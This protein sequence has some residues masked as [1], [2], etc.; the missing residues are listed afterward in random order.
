MSSDVVEACSTAVDG[1]TCKT[2]TYSNT[3]VSIFVCVCVCVTQWCHAYIDEFVV[4]VSVKTV[5]GCERRIES[6][7]RPGL[8]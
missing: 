2:D 7:E 8:S 5:V 3:Q 4:T 1:R 6:D